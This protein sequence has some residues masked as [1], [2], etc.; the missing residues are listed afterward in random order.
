E[1]FDVTLDVGSVV[2]K[3]VQFIHD[4]LQLGPLTDEGLSFLQHLLFTATLVIWLTE[5]R[6]RAAKSIAVIVGALVA[7]GAE[8]GQLFIGARMPGVEE[9]AAALAGALLGVPIGMSFFGA[10][11]SARWWIG[12][13]VLTAVGV[14]M[15]QLSPFTLVDEPRPFQWV[16]FLNYYTFTTSE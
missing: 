11:R 10:Q 15:Q 8:G 6:V 9:A 5:I 3:F 16:P 12:L 1:P 2:P 4:P 14:A 7:L 13:F